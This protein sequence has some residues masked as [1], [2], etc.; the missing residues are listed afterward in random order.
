MDSDNDVREQLQSQ[1]P[2]VILIPEN[3]STPKIVNVLKIIYLI[4][5]VLFVIALFILLITAK[6]NWIGLINTF[7]YGSIFIGIQKRKSWVVPLVFYVN[8]VS[9]VSVTFINIPL[10]IKLI[11]L[12]FLIFGIYFFSRKDVKDY[13]KSEGYIL[14]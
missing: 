5:T 13:F 7:A 9:L 12:I 3:S 1:Q 4:L 8:S 10:F 2:E 14:F 11:Y 6:F